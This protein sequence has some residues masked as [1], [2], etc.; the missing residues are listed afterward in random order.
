[1]LALLMI[2]DIK[3]ARFINP[4]MTKSL[5][6]RSSAFSNT[7]S[8]HPFVNRREDEAP[9]GMPLF[10]VD[11]AEIEG[12]EEEGSV[13]V[14]EG[15]EDEQGTRHHLHRSHFMSSP[16]CVR[17]GVCS[18]GLCTLLLRGLSMRMSALLK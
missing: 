1:M 4:M 15:G 11:L 14:H 6:Q 9:G 8:R 13:V 7:D 16:S 18:R 17:S 2:H 5:W 12:L 3:A 10:R